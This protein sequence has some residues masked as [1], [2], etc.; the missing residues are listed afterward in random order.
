MALSTISLGKDPLIL[1]L[2]IAGRPLRWIPW[3]TAVVLMSREMVAWSAGERSF[4]FRGGINRLTG[5]RSKITVSSIVAVKG[6]DR[7]GEG[8]RLTPP[9]SNREL[10]LR[11][12]HLCMYCGNEF[13]AQLLTRDHLIPLS[14][15]GKDCWINVVAAC[16]ACNHAKGARTP[17]QAGMKLLAIPYTPN[18]AEYL[19]LSNRRILADQMS[20]LK[21]RFRRAGR[22]GRIG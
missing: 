7:D 1:R 6:K 8:E 16:R 10:F 3:Q 5:H 9:L 11:D 17:D 15:G 18:R 22:S 4:T 14:Q 2:D 21:K 13:P 20:F 19:V 12:D